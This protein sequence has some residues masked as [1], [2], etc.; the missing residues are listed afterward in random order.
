[1]TDVTAAPRREVFE[2]E[3][4][5]WL[6]A[7]PAPPG[8]SV[9]T[10][11]PDVTEVPLAFD[12]WR[13]WFRQS[14]EQILRWVPDDGAALF[15]QSDIRREGAW[16]D[17]GYLVQRAAE[18]AGAHL[19]WHTI[20]CR[21]PAGTLSQGRAT[22]SHLLAFSRTLLPPRRPRP[23]VLPDAGA[24][25]WPKAMGR[26][27]CLLA[28]SYLR[29]DTT[30]RLVVDP[31]CGHGTVLAAANSLGLDAIGVDLSAKRCRIARHFVLPA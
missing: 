16:V 8:A 23:D 5:G 11:L 21:R 28:C 14:A 7:N 1:M 20:V 26:N 19:L 12:A 4:L 29:D 17:K 10:S 22:Y 2:A 24:M 6:A 31:F 15:F 27:A 25:S 13:A 3:A 30:T 9:V 18:D